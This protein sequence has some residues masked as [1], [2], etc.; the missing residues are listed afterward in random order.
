MAGARTP[1]ELETMLEDACLLRDRA[2]LADLFEPA[3]VLRTAGSPRQLCG[4]EQIK[5]FITR[6]AEN[7]GSYLA[8]RGTVLQTQDTALIVTGHAINVVRRRRNGTWR[9]TILFLTG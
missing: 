6:L 1:E 2:T 9:Y 5:D 8:D 7:Q 4:R 3:A